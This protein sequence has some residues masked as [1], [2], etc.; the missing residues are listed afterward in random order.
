WDKLDLNV[1]YC[2]NGSLMQPGPWRDT[3]AVANNRLFDL[4]PA[5]LM[6]TIYSFFIFAGTKEEMR[7][8][9]TLGVFLSIY[10]MASTQIMSQ[11]VFMFDRRS[12]THAKSVSPSIRISKL[13]SWKLKDAS[14]N[15]F[16]GDH[17]S[18]LLIIT[19][20]ICFYTRKK[21]YAIPAVITA[22][23]FALPRVFSGGHWASDILIGSGSTALIFL[24]IAFY[25]PFTDKCLAKLENPVNKSCDFLA[26]FIPALKSD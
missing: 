14:K 24:P 23:I 26:K 17:A 13:Y 15:S 16:P 22:I 18:V 2:L 12:P 19:G 3:L 10:M 5:V 25:T 1:F 7:K 21:R 20:F 8:R 4:V 9:I 11:G 6:V